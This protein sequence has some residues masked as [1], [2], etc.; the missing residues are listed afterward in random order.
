MVVDA[1]TRN[2]E[3][4]GEAAKRVP[5]ELRS[6]YEAIDWRRVADFRDIAIHAYFAVDVEMVW[7][8]ATERL[9]ELKVVVQQMLQD[10]QGG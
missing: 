2:L 1:V 5:G 4:I 8:I 6:R 9:G 7:T 10:I 3:V